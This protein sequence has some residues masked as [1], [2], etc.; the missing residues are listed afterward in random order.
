MRRRLIVDP[1]RA[2]LVVCFFAFAALVGVAGWSWPLELA[3][4]LFPVAALLLS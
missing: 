1:R 3:A 2:A 4:V